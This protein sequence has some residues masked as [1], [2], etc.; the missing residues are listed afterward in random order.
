MNIVRGLLEKYR[1]SGNQESA[2]ETEGDFLDDDMSPF[3][4]AQGCHRAATMEER[5]LATERPDRSFSRFSSS[6]D[7]G[8]FREFHE[9]GDEEA[10]IEGN[11]LDLLREQTALS[12]RKL[13]SWIG[14]GREQLGNFGSEPTPSSLKRYPVVSNLDK[15]PE[16]SNSKSDRRRTNLGLDDGNLVCDKRCGQSCSV[17]DEEFESSS[18]SVKNNDISLTAFVRSKAQNMRRDIILRYRRHKKRAKKLSAAE[19][20]RNK[21][22]TN[23]SD[24][25]TKVGS[26]TGNKSK[27]LSSL[28]DFIRTK[29]TSRN[30]KE[31]NSVSDRV[32]IKLA[33]RR[34]AFEGY[35]TVQITAHIRQKYFKES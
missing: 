24:A 32:A 25:H 5:R 35:S 16:V 10:H 1:P 14:Y 20:Y 26:D 22:R 17:V 13:R 3:Q 29:I 27:R 6:P 21:Y 34:Q 23:G 19:F 2:L 33:K 7:L 31:V 28:F 8:K 12:A 30:A 4:R 15:I 11:V 18:M 9:S